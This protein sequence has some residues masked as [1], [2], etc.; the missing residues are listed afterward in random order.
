MMINHL[1][2]PAIATFI[3]LGGCHGPTAPA[4]PPERPAQHIYIDENWTTQ[5]D[6]RAG[7]VITL[8]MHDDG[9][10]LD[11]CEHSGGE[12]IYNPYTTIWTCDG[13]DF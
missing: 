7:D 11:R 3:A 6:A 12:L 9:G 1:I 13:V 8:I 2:K 10:Q 4:T 5:F